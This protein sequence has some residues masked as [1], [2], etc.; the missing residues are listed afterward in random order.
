MKFKINHKFFFK[1]IPILT[2]DPEKEKILIEDIIKKRRLSYSLELKD[3]DGNKYL[4]VN[5]FGS[6][7]NYVKKEGEGYFLEEEL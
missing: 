1:R 6:E 5:N 7:I 4:V 3:V 2:M